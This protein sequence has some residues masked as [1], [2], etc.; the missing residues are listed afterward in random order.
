MTDE[1]L[2]LDYLE[3]NYEVELGYKYYTIIDKSTKLEYSFTR[4][5]NTGFT[6]IFISLFGEFYIDDDKTS[7]DLLESWYD[8]KCYKLTKGLDEFF[9]T[10]DGTLGSDIIIDNVKSEFKNIG[11][12][13]SFYNDRFVKHYYEKWLSPSLDKYLE[14]LDMSIG[15][16]ACL[17][18]VLDNYSSDMKYGFFKGKIIKDF[19]NHYSMFFFASINDYISNNKGNVLDELLDGIKDR[20]ELETETYKHEGEKIIK[21]WYRVNVLDDKLIPFFRE[22]VITLGKSDWVVTWIGHGPF[23]IE[24]LLNEFKDEKRYNEK[25]VIERYEQWFSEEV[26]SASERY[27]TKAW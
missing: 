2:I 3:E 25:Y 13:G 27:L 7:I 20:L 24:K 15:S 26:I 5:F 6:N 16:V 14:S 18:K 23:T 9:E 4:A 22:L 1:K 12:N 8:K 17:E 11:N 21:E 10:Y 19:N